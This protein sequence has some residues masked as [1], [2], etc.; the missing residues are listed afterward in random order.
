MPSPPSIAG[1]GGATDGTG[2]SSP[3]CVVSLQAAIP[4]QPDEQLAQRVRAWKP[5]S[6][7]VNARRACSEVLRSRVEDIASTLRPS[8]A[9]PAQQRMADLRS[10]IVARQTPL[11]AAAQTGGL[12]LPRPGTPSS[13]RADT[14]AASHVH[15]AKSAALIT[16]TDVPR[17]SIHDSPAGAERAQ[18]PAAVCVMRVTGTDVP[19]SSTRAMQAN[20]WMPSSARVVTPRAC[21]EQL[22]HRVECVASTLRPSSA[23]PAL[24]RASD[25]S[26]CVGAGKR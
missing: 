14:V 23:A 13:T 21:S 25:F 11:T 20:A 16:G 3:A 24:H 4:K 12:G 9:A 2:G 22:R 6:A 10:R 15:H 7:I 18:L 19:G 5:P 1:T 26:D 17:R 8:S